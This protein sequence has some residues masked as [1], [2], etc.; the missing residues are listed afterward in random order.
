MSG[1][2]IDN[3]LLESKLAESKKIPGGT[4]LGFRRDPI[5]TLAS[6][7]K[8]YGDICYINVGRYRPYL[9]NNP[10][11][12]Q[13]ILAESH[14]SVVKG[15]LLRGAKKVLG[16]G[17]L[18]SEGDYHHKEKRLIQPAFHH[19]RI[20][21]YARTMTERAEYMTSEWTD[22][23]VLNVHEKMTHLSM[24]IVARCLFGADIHSRSSEIDKA[25]YDTVGYFGKLSS[26]F[27]RL[28]DK[29]PLPNYQRY[30]RA[31]QKLDDIVYQIIRERRA[32]G[33]QDT[34]DLLSMLLK[35][36]DTE[37]QGGTMTDKE[38]RD[39]IITL[40]MA[41]LETT[42]NAMTWSWY[43]LSQNQSVE[44]KMHEEIDRVLGDRSLPNAEDYPKLSYTMNVF[45]E[46]L[47]VYPPVWA[48]GR[49]VVSELVLGE[50]SI[51]AGSF[52]L[53]SQ[54]VM[55]HDPRFYENPDQ[56]NPDRWT[57]Q[58]QEKLPK[59]AYFQF[60]GGPRVC[61]GEPFAWFEGVMVLSTIGRKWRMKHAPRHKVEMLPRITLQPKDGMLMEVSKRRN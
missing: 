26:P 9:V 8:K 22:G 11:Y 54:Y 7:A 37:G 10:I 40:F 2:S 34:G 52:I 43:L 57:K 1:D 55:H 15:P 20:A 38:V 35:A 61:V 53:M 19:E 33:K 49:A 50:Y 59:F 27:G 23:L 18:T 25:L 13:K 45:R 21:S 17:L 48:L 5:R 39:E 14:K 30:H 56:F 4:M 41:G 51:P 6:A 47:R 58:M 29:L 31:A 24:D 3:Q 46:T 12:I 32:N 36:V 42:A 16:E 44:E 28:L 60:G